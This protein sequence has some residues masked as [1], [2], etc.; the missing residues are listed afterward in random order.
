[1][2]QRYGL[3]NIRTIYVLGFYGLL[4]SASKTPCIYLYLENEQA[5]LFKMVQSLGLD[6][7]VC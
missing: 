3:C 7:T 2:F 6:L 4:F 1:M 5:D